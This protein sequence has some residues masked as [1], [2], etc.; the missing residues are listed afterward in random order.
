M[1]AIFNTY[2]HHAVRSHRFIRDTIKNRMD[3]ND[4]SIDTNLIF[5]AFHAQDAATNTRQHRSF[6]QFNIHAKHSA[7]A[8]RKLTQ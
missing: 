2:V 3:E 6:V 1:Y 5:H 4:N 7:N 8:K